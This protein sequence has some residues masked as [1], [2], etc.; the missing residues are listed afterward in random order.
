MYVAGRIGRL[1]DAV[2]SANLN[3]FSL[4]FEN[5]FFFSQK[6]GSVFSN[7]LFLFL[8]L[9]LRHYVEAG[10]GIF[11]FARILGRFDLERKQA[12]RD[13]E[14]KY[15]GKGGSCTREIKRGIV[16]RKHWQKKIRSHWL[17]RL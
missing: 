13:C 4:F 16:E 12:G 7:S 8:H 14:R 11:K 10:F 2:V 1:M 17:L 6:P 3:S 15:T 5:S 9:V